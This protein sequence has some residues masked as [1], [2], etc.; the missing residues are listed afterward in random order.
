MSDAL[1]RKTKQQLVDIIFRK[2]DVHK[3]LNKKI[4]ELGGDLVLKNNRIQDL[5]DINKRLNTDIED[6]VLKANGLT[7]ACDEYASKIQEYINANKH[8]KYLSAITSILAITL[9]MIMMC[10]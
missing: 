1:M 8:Y 6:V 7:E 2:D 10:L 9:L 4:E 3:E 5:E